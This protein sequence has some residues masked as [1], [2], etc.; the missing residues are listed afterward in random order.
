MALAR[1]VEKKFGVK[2]RGVP[3]PN[4]AIDVTTSVTEIVKGNP[5]RLM[6]IVINLG[7]NDIWV[8]FD[9]EIATNRGILLTANGGFLTLTADEDM[10]L[11]GYPIYGVAATGTN[12]VYV[13]ETEAE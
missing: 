8:G 11:V 12:R 4:G 13:H 7:A 3:N 5:D 2:T 6:I 1:Y 10:E 9:R